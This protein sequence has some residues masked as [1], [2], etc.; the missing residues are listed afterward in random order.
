MQRVENRVSRQILGAPVYTPVAALQREIRALAVKGRDMKVKLKFAN[1]VA[2]TAN[3]LLAPIFQKLTRESRPKIWLRQLREYIGELGRDTDD[4][5][6]EV[7][8]RENIRWRRD[9]ESETILEL[10]TGKR[11]MGVEGI[12]IDEY[13]FI[14]S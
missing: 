8:N 12:C 9:I 1:Y 3:G 10:Y 2:N 14:R 11:N 13:C 7:N 6:R 5:G 4:I